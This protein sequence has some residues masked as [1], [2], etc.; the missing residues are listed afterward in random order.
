MAEQPFGELVDD[1]ADALLALSLS[2][3]VLFWN[4][5]A[6]AIFGYT[7]ADAVGQQLDALIVAPEERAAAQRALVETIERGSTSYEAPRRH[8]SG[9]A[10]LVDVAM[11]KVE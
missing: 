5:G 10:L 9:A 8:K 3:V 7:T 11:R 1:A 4:R 2:G 6:E